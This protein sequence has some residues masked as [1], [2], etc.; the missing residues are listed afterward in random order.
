ML[1]LIFPSFNKVVDDIV[2]L[3]RGISKEQYFDKCNNFLNIKNVMLVNYIDADFIN[4]DLSFLKD[5]KIHIL[6]NICEPTISKNQ[7]K[8]LNIESVHVARTNSMRFKKSGKRISRNGDIYGKKV[9]YLPNEINKYWY[10]NNC[11]LLGVAF[12][13]KVLKAQRIILFGFDFYQEEEFFQKPVNQHQGYIAEESKKTG[14]EEKI[15]FLDF[16]KENSYVDYFI[17]SNTDFQ[18]MKNLHLV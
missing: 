6:F 4:D 2:I 7:I 18:P 1:N 14:H 15:M 10:L 13:T 11:G 12:A 8:T 17:C 16:V 5:K 9:K 3:G